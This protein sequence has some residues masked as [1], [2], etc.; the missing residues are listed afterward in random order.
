M[1]LEILPYVIGAAVSPILLIL[2]ILLLSRPKN[3]KLHTTFYALGCLLMVSV[4]GAFL[5]FFVH[6]TLGKADP[7]KQT[8]YIHIGLAILLYF[9]AWHSLNKKPKKKKAK[10]QSFVADFVLGLVMMALNFSTLIMFLPAAVD[11][12]QSGDIVRLIGLAMM[13]AG[14]MVP[15]IVPLLIILLL[16]KSGDA[17]LA[18]LG[19]FMHRYGNA[20]TAVFI[21]LIA[22]YVLYRGVVGLV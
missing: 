17:I 8:D 22:T 9:L 4:I 5:F 6:F 3:P 15:V 18:R 2:T 11:L 7:S 16:G 19:K 12:E 13:I 21:A 14:A 1:P 10:Q 20:I